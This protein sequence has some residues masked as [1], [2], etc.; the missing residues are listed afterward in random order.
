MEPDEREML[1]RVDERTK[2]IDDRIEG[3]NERVA[4]NDEAI[5]TIEDDVN[6]NSLIVNGI[7][8][9][10]ASAGTALAGKI[11]GWLPF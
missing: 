9:S 6:R 11:F 8:F 5:D 4:A 7:G 1:L 10:I 2:R 3:V